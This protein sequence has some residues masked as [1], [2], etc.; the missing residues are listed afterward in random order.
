MEN[1]NSVSEEYTIDLL[2]LVMVLWKKAWLIVLCGI[3][4]AGIGF[5]ISAF[6]I[7]PTYS[8]TIKLYANNNSL[9]L[10]SASFSISSAD[11]SASRSL[12]A[13]YGE[14]LNNRTTLERVIEKAESDFTYKE[15]S[16]MI[17]YGSSNNTEV[18]YVKV[19]TEDPYEASLIANCIAEVLPERISEI[20][21]GATMEVVDSAI[22][23][24]QKVNPSI[25]KYTVIGFILG[26]MLCAAVI[27]VLD[28]L[29]DTIHD[30]EH[31][32]NTYDYPLL[33]RIPDLLSKSSQKYGYYHYQ[34]N[35]D[36]FGG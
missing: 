1:N 31:I 20:I 22:P 13:T 18:M 17:Q 26:A 21:N 11:I 15:L 7:H 2:H 36:I 10:G 33:A 16:R 12:V 27:V 35:D 29:D 32:L 3:L 25:S 5:A 6:V 4:A 9:S 8:S 34:K 24:L 23:I 28:I 19:T 14:I 30:E